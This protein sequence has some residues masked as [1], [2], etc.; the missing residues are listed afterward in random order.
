MLECLWLL[1]YI[2]VEFYELRSGFVQKMSDKLCLHED[3]SVLYLILPSLRGCITFSIPP[4]V[5]GKV[6]IEG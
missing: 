4:T 2:D 5:N 3:T 1:W 6:T